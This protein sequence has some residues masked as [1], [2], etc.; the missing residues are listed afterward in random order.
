[1]G[2]ADREPLLALLDERE[3]QLHSLLHD[4]VQGDVAAPDR[5]LPRIDADAFQE[6]VDELCQTQRATFHGQHELPR[7]G[8]VQLG[9]PVAQQ[10]ERGE[11][12]RQ[13]CLELVRDVREHRVAQ[14][15]AGLYLRLVA[16]QLEL[17]PVAEGRPGSRRAVGLRAGAGDDDRAPFAAG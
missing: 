16:H 5:V 11:L 4:L 15:P 8:G 12:R 2:E 6:V 7:L 14:P 10:L 17:P 9:K 13:R 1:M 3:G